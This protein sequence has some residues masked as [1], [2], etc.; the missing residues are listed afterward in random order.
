MDWINKPKFC[1][2][3]LNKMHWMLLRIRKTILVFTL[4]VIF[5][6]YIYTKLPFRYSTLYTSRWN[7]AYELK[8]TSD[9]LHVVRQD[10]TRK[11]LLKFLMFMMFMQKQLASYF[12]KM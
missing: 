3:R 9:V 11:F 10:P 7:K 2:W 4:I 6:D 8:T 12:A 5:T 1:Y